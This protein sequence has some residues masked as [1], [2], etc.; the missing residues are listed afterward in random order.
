M[1]DP[2]I[3]KSISVG[4]ALLFLSAAWHKYSGLAQFRGAL[5]DYRILPSFLIGPA[6]WLLPVTETLLGIGWLTGRWQVPVAITSAA[7]LLLYAVAIGIN[8]ARGR[9]H[10]GCGC[11]APGSNTRSL[12]A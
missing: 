2:I 9:V 3:A 1:I 11:G 7:L 12:V 5:E 4:M 8:V 10:I 6:T